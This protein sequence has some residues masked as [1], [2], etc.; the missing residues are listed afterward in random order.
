MRFLKAFLLFLGFLYLAYYLR[1]QKDVFPL[2]V[3]ESYVIAQMNRA[4]QEER[5]EEAKALARFVID[6]PFYSQQ[7]KEEAQ[8]VYSQAQAQLDSFFYRA[9]KCGKSALTGIPEDMTSLFCVFVSDMTLFGDVRDTVRETWKK[10]TGEEPDWFI[11]GLSALGLTSPVFD[12]GRALWKSGAISE[13]FAKLILREKSSQSLQ[14]IYALAKLYKDSGV[15]LAPF[16]RSLKHVENKQEFENLSK[17][18]KEHGPATAYVAVLKTEG[19][20]LEKPYRLLLCTDFS[21]LVRITLKDF[22]KGG[23]VLMEHAVRELSA[24][25]GL[26]ASF[27]FGL[28]FALAYIL[29]NLLLP[30]RSF[31]WT[32]G[33][34]SVLFTAGI[35]LYSI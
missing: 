13:P 5:F 34:A 28:F 25:L 35:I 33:F 15:G 22:K 24:K 17:L 9:K 19:K 32:L 29:L 20:V 10:L 26:P 18:V 7:A 2:L 30:P 6:S 11:L 14:E 31:L 4:F 12:L 23:P 3:S 16:A 1:P 21:D 8:R 27:V